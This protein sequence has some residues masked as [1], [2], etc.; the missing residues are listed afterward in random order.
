MEGPEV[1]LQGAGEVEDG[2]DRG[3]GDA[4]GG[5][6]L[7]EWDLGVGGLE[8]PWVVVDVAAE[9]A[10]A[11]VGEEAVTLG[12]EVVQGVGLGVGDGAGGGVGGLE[13]WGR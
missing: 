12:E 2:G 6:D 1:D 3:E 5:G 8:G 4:V 11:G 9:D 7:V 10:A 13:G